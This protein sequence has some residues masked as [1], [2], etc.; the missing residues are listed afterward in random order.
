MGA[1][2]AYDFSQPCQ[3]GRESWWSISLTVDAVEYEHESAVSIL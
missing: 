3:C 2:S 1:R